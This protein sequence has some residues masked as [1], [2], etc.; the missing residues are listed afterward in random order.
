VGIGAEVTSVMENSK[1][2]ATSYAFSSKNIRIAGNV[3]G[4]GE[5]GW[6]AVSLFQSVM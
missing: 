6:K 4:L 2:S 3:V 5:F 1:M